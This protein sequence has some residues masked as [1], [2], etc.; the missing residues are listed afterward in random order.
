M[1]QT[2]IL[3]LTLTLANHNSNFNPNSNSEALD[4]VCKEKYF[5]KPEANRASGEK[6][7][8]ANR[9]APVSTGRR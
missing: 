5:Q 7:N 9:A 2:L 4:V 8:W 6:N 3:T 1:T